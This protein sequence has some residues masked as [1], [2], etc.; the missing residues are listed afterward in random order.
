MKKEDERI[1]VESSYGLLVVDGNGDVVVEESDLDGYLLDIE[2]V[3]LEDLEQFLDS[4]GVENPKGVD[5]ID[6]L[7][8]GFWNKDGSYHKADEGWRKRIRE[9]FLKRAEEKKL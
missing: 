7:S 3:D 6:V 8:I 2:K 1:E 5:Q 9:A 4:V